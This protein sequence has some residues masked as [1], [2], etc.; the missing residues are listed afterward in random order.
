MTNLHR[1]SGK[2]YKPSLEEPGDLDQW[3]KAL[4]AAIG[5]KAARS[6]LADYEVRSKD[7]KVT[8]FGR[9]VASQ[10]AAALRKVL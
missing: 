1:R 10:Q 9:D 6:I 3:A 2:R 4:V 8:K 7:P 5:K